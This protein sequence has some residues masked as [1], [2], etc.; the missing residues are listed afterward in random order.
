VLVLTAIF[1][2][3]KGDNSR[4]MNPSAAHA[5][6]KALTFPKN[7]GQIMFTPLT[8]RGPLLPERKVKAWFAT[9]ANNVTKGKAREDPVHGFLAAMKKEAKAL[10]LATL[11]LT[12]ARGPASR[13]QPT[14]AQ[15]RERATELEGM[16]GGDKALLEALLSRRGD[17]VRHF[18]LA[19]YIEG[20]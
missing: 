13:Q 3:G 12:P 16:V 20:L 8:E 1:E 2:R 11:Q 15:L 9:F 5:F 10:A 14:E 7:S 6:M 18:Q 4:K 17:V 19:P